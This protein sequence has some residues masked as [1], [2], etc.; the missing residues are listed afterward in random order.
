MTKEKYYLIREVEDM[1]G[2]HRV[3]VGEYDNPKDAIERAN[4]KKIFLIKGTKI[5]LKLREIPK[6]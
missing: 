1:E 2:G 6:D 5:P 4:K 3:L